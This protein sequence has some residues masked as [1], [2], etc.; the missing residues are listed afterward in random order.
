MSAHLPESVDAWRM[1]SARRS[2]IGSFPVARLARLRPLLAGDSGNVDYQL[3]FGRDDLGAAYLGLQVRAAVDL[4]CQR[5]LEPFRTML[6]LD[7][8]LG[9]IRDEADEFALPP[10]YE[11][12][13]VQ[14]S[15]RLEDVIE[16]ELLLALPL[17]PVRPGSE[18][19]IAPWQAEAQEPVAAPPHPFAGLHK[20]KHD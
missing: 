15:I 7:L 5:T 3:E 17:V 19:A 13:L 12:L 8:R 1:V 18:S 9:L 11:A 2:F 20:L 14:D 10:G 4:L 6:A 16:D